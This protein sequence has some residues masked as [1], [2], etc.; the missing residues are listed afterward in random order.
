MRDF[1]LAFI[2][3]SG[4]EY[5]NLGAEEMLREAAPR[6]AET[7]FWLHLGANLSARDWHDSVGGLH[8]LP[9]TDSQRY[10][11]VSPPLL[12][13]ARQVFA[14][15]T[16]LEA[17]YGSDVLSAGE[18][19]N[20]IAAGYPSLAGVFGLHRFHHVAE[21]DERCVPVEA[22]AQTILAFRQLVERALA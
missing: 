15:L 13:A 7:A 1:D 21:D 6:P 3:N 10:L 18:L 8:P 17:P 2:A 19:T 20:I 4:H 9:G 12:S 11:V 14:G 22:V 5:S 16:G